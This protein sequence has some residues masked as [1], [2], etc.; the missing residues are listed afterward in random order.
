MTSSARILVLGGSGM[1]GH[2]V[3]R[4]LH[5]RFEVFGTLRSESAI[6][7]FVQALPDFPAHHLAPS[8]D[9]LNLADVRKTLDVVKPTVVINCIGV[10]KQSNALHHAVPSIQLNALF[11]HQLAQLC[12]ASGI[13]VIHFSTDCVFSGR[14]GNYGEED[15]PDP[16]DLYG[17]SKLLGEI[18]MPGCLTLRTSLIGWE[19]QHQ[20]SLLG[21]FAA[22]R[23]KRIRGY[24]RAI[25]SGLTTSEMAGL[26]G[27]IIDKQPQLSGVYHVASAPISK[28]DL[29][30]GL[31]ET[32]GW[33]DIEIQPDADFICDRSL[34]GER[35]RLVT[36]WTAP[37]WS[38]MIA[39][40]A[41]ERP[42]YERGAPTGTHT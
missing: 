26:L 41:Q 18:D 35:F 6:R 15:V 22:Q 7:S 31:Q 32:L 29:L 42:M 11:P 17:R 3:L 20:R 36:G 33:S 28:F 16:I 40:L 9:A 24:Q 34:S 5:R 27:H 37:P 4:T 21:W 39:G 30:C 23:G 13:R 10:V 14:A 12:L 25:F 38:R 8:I 1:L 2:Q 19:L